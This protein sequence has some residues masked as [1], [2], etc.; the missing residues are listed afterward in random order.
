MSESSQNCFNCQR[1][2]AEI[3]VIAWRYQ[4]QSL[5][6]CSE[7]MPMLIHKWPQVVGR[8]GQAETLP[9]D[10]PDHKE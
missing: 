9:A 2:E 4:G 6:V 8:L 3:P 10:V 7:C 1:S 5:W